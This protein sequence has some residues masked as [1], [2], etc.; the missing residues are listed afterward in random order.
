[1]KILMELAI[2]GGDKPKFVFVSTKKLHLQLETDNVHS[3]REGQ[4][5][6][7]RH[8]TSPLSA[9]RRPGTRRSLVYS[10]VFEGEESK[11]ICF[12]CLQSHFLRVFIFSSRILPVFIP[13]FGSVSPTR[14]LGTRRSLVNPGVFE[15]GESKNICFS[16]PQCHFLRVLFFFPYFSRV[17]AR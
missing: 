12:P 8:R 17:L 16:C 14:R 15:G 11:N 5:A 2:F 6:A 9:T 7:S 1:M 4:T 10:G 13:S 3:S